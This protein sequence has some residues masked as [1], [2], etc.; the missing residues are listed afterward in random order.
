VVGEDDEWRIT[1]RFVSH[2]LAVF[3]DHVPKGLGENY[4]RDSGC[5]LFDPVWSEMKDFI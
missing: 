3:G 4:V 2:R 1:R 5:V